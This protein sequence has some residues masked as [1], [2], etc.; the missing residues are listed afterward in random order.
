[1]AGCPT[2]DFR[3]W[4]SQNLFEAMHFSTIPFCAITFQ[5]LQEVTALAVTFRPVI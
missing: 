3:G 2:L 4:D 1:M 5:P